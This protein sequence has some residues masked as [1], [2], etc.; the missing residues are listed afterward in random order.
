MNEP[1]TFSLPLQQM[2]DSLYAHN[3][4]REICLASLVILHSQSG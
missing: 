3:I 1:V 2:M 4:T